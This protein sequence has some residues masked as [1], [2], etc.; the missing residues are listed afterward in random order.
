M[1]KIYILLLFMI[2]LS[3]KQKNDS[4][5]EVCKCDSNLFSRYSLFITNVVVIDTLDNYELTYNCASVNFNIKSIFNSKEN[6]ESFNT[7]CIS[8]EVNKL[9]L[10]KDFSYSTEEMKYMEITVEGARL[11]F[12]EEVKNNKKAMFMVRL[13]EKKEIDLIEKI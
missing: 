9:R 1:K 11:D 12:F 13:N 7:D 6:N 2:T 4:K 3:C 8:E 10:T 5:Q